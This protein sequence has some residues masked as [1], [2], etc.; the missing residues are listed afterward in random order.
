MFMQPFLDFM[1]ALLP[2]FNN[3]PSKAYLTQIIEAVLINLLIFQD[4]MKMFATYKD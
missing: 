2:L 3:D 4:K 1:A